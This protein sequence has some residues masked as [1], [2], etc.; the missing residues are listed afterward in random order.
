MILLDTHVL[1]WHERGDSRLGSEAL[2]TFRQALQEGNIA[3]SA[4]TFWEV[5]M[6][7]QKGQLDFRL[8][9]DEWRQDLLGQGIVELAVDGV[10]ATRASLLPDMRGDPADRIIV[11]T[12]KQGHHL[13]TADQHILEWTG[14]LSCLDARK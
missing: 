1:L 10:I 12:A 9:L 14:Q 3:V 4:I 6:R 2:R 11:A 13:M 5:G 8:D 7:V